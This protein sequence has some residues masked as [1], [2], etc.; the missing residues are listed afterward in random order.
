MI[1]LV[2][3]FQ[4]VCVYLAVQEKESCVH[5]CRV[6]LI[7]KYESGITKTLLNVNLSVL[8]LYQYVYTSHGTEISEW[9]FG[10]RELLACK[11]RINTQFKY[12]RVS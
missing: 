6:V 1:I 7:A 8:K 2:K 10:F 4:W 12:L 5:K 11:S 3:H 9:E